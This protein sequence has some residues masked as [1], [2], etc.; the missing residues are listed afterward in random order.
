MPPSMTKDIIFK[1]MRTLSGHRRAD[2]DIAAQCAAG[3]TL[4]PQE[5]VRP[6]LPLILNRIV[7]LH[8]L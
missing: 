8:A 5:K 4:P 1:A 2:I 6:L 3:M 7:N